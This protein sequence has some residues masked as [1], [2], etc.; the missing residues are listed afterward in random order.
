MSSSG[1]GIRMAVRRDC[2]V[3]ARVVRASSFTYPVSVA[4]I[5]ALHSIGY[6]V[7]QV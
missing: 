2:S 7:P 6:A 1:E 5:T 4:T 3:V